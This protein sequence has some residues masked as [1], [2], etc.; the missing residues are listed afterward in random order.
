M[1][2][3]YELGILFPSPS[4]VALSPVRHPHSHLKFNSAQEAYDGENSSHIFRIHSHERAFYLRDALI[5]RRSFCGYHANTMRQDVRR[6]RLLTFAGV[7]VVQLLES[8]PVKVVR[9]CPLADAPL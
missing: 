6:V 4:G 5:S 2:S 3:V 7:T 1:Q 8:V 9:N